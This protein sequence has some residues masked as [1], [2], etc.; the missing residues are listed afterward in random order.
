[1]EKLS[2]PLALTHR[3]LIKV[4]GREAGAARAFLQGLITCNMDAV[5]PGNPAFGALL[6]PQGKILV[7]FI[8][9]AVDTESFLID[10]ARSEVPSLLKRLTLFRLRAPIDLTDVSDQFA[11]TLITGNEPPALSDPAQV[12]VPDPRAASLGT[13]I[14]DPCGEGALS[15]DDQ[16]DDDAF[17][18][19]RTHLIKNG[20]G[21]IATVFAP[22]K[23]F[24]LDVNYDR[25]NGVDYAKGC[26]VGQEV[27]S[28][29]KRK[30]SVRKRTVFISTPDDHE[31]TGADI[32]RDGQSIGQIIGAQRSDAGMIGL[33]LVRV[34]RLDVALESVTALPISLRLADREIPATMNVPGYLMDTASAPTP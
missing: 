1:M 30:G 22:D 29:M 26:F 8:I 9:C 17:E 11:M 24:L 23:H 33:G 3:G 21:E 18:Q 2:S 15:T 5:T 27:T 6:T 25:L 14:Y 34:D 19:Y 32:L 13:R 31:I 20:V 28:R 10:C 12:R 7:D 4:R 16:S